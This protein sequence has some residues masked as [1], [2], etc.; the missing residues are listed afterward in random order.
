[1][2]ISILALGAVLGALAMPLVASAQASGPT[3]DS[4]GA[5]ET[6]KPSTAGPD[7]RPNEEVLRN[8]EPQMQ[9][10]QAQPPVTDPTRP[11]SPAPNR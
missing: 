7:T 8:R 9:S 3:T 10:N 4:G 2:K 11:V 1:M 5:K 6:M